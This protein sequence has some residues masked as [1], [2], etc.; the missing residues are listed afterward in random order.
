MMDFIDLLGVIGMFLL[1]VG[2]PLAITVG[3]VYLLK[4]L[5]RRWEAEAR[6]PSPVFAP[7]QP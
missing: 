3:V 1:R 2:V 7:A 6:A 5:D 4:R